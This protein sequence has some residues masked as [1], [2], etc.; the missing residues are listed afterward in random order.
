MLVASFLP[1]IDLGTWRRTARAAAA[2]SRSVPRP[3]LWVLGGTAPP[4]L[5]S[6][7]GWD[8]EAE[9]PGEGRE[10]DGWLGGEVGLKKHVHPE[11]IMIRVRS[12][13]RA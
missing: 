4:S 13:N 3:A 5:A 7:E 9:R 12:K 11:N 10:G 8:E 6:V 2:T 1:P